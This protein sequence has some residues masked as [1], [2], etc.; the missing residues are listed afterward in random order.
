MRSLVTYT[1]KNIIS[2]WTRLIAFHLECTPGSTPRLVYLVTY[3]HHR[4]SHRIWSRTDLRFF[5][6]SG[7]PQ[8][9][10]NL[11]TPIQVQLSHFIDRNTCPQ[12]GEITSQAIRVVWHQRWRQSS[13]PLEQRPQ[14]VRLWCQ[15]SSMRS[16]WPTFTWKHVT[17]NE[18]FTLILPWVRCG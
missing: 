5:S 6:N 18:N 15:F 17:Q 9:K 4:A 3:P 11:K 2:V 1:L 8:G 13:G 14:A 7:I 12:T 10:K 16:G